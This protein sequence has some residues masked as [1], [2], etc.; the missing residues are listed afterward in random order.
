M[1]ACLLTISVNQHHHAAHSRYVENPHGLVRPMRPVRKW[2][3]AQVQL[4]RLVRKWP[5]EPANGLVRNE[6]LLRG[7][8]KAVSSGLD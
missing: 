1:F 5:G 2:P 3:C 4:V 6:D 7:S 8:V